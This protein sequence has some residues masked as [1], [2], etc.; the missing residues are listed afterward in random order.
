MSGENIFAEERKRM[1]VELV[2]AEEKVTVPQLC[3]RFSVSP[4]TVRNDL[5]ELEAF[6]LI[7][8]THGGAIRNS[9]ANFEPNAY[10][11]EVAYIRE[12][13]DIAAAA[14]QYVKRGDTIALDT[15]TTLY[16]FAKRLTD[17]DDLTIIT[18]DLQ[19]A[20]YLERY[21]S[22]S[23]IF[24]GG[25]IRRD[26]HCTV[27]AK[28]LSDLNGLNV[29]KA[30]M[31]SNSISL[32][33]GLTTPNIEMARIKEKIIEIADQVYLLADSSKIGKTSFVRFADIEDVDILVT[34][35]GISPSTL[36]KFESSNVTVTTVN[37][38]G[39]EEE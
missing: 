35:A 34:D 2:N 36:A 10:D 16:E 32:T 19:I 6:G 26:F 24:V 4:A 28:A 12:K 37:R 21:S 17:I 33:K 9:R 11:K 29:D 38:N 27:G 5:R 31:A 18:N 3:D 30:F 20:I 7:T 15:G 14:L 39:A 1:I 22:A 25:S 8:R 13:R 23:I